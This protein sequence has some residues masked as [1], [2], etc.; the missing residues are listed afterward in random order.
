M[1]FTVN[2]CTTKGRPMKGW[3]VVNSFFKSQKLNTLYE[4]LSR[5]CAKRHVELEVRPTDS[6]LCPIGQ[7]ITATYGKPDFV[8]F[9]DKDILLARR[10][11]SEGVP[12]FNNAHGIELADNKALTALALCG[13]VPTPTTIIAP[14]TFEGIGYNKTEFL[15]KAATTLGL[16]MVIKEVYGS[17]GKQVYLANSIDDAEQIVA[18]IGW[19]DFVMQQYIA[20]SRGSDVRINVVGDRVVC[21]MSRYNPNDF[22]SNISNGGAGKA[23]VPSAE[24]KAVAVAATKA[25]GLDFAGV[26]ILHG[27]HAP[28]QDLYTNPLVCEVNSNPHFKSSFDATGIDVSQYIVDYI[29]DKLK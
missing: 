6:L 14:K 22:R 25:L 3:L 7:S 9:W 18:Q 29:I 15:Q 12:L 1:F 2:F 28:D 20:A 21:A 26:D 19:K 17:F 4:F 5:S 10:L 23:F 8:L 24:L 11:E 13:K 16:P 27:Q